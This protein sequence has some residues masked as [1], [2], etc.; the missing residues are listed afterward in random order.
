MMTDLD[1]LQLTVCL[2]CLSEQ[3]DHA[4]IFFVELHLLYTS[5]DWQET[6]HRPLPFP[7]NLNF[8]FFFIKK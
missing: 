3:I 6:F 2:A 7:F 1:R 4:L 8:F 5:S